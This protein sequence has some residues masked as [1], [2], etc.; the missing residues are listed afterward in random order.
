MEIRGPRIVKTDLKKEN[1]KILISRFWYKA[2]VIMIMWHWYIN[3]TKGTEIDAHAYGQ[4][5]F[6]KVPR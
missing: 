3:R 4:C 5:I 6:K 2:T 1:L